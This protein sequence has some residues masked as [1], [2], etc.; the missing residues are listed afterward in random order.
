VIPI[1]KNPGV[2][3]RLDEVILPK[4]FYK[5]PSLPFPEIN[6]AFNAREYAVLGKSKLPKS[7]TIP[8]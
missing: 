5:V 6:E 4:S 1:G 7:K 8:F 2:S 3:L